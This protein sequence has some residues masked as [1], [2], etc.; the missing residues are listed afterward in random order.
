MATPSP[1]RRRRNRPQRGPN[2]DK[3]QKIL[4]PTMNVP[5]YEPV[6]YTHLTLPTI[7]SV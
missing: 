2:A 6:S 4:Q 5:F 1:K 3:I 7:Y